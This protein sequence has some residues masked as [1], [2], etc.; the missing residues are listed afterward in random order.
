MREFDRPLICS[1]MRKSEMREGSQSLLVQF[2]LR[3]CRA[4]GLK[5]NG[6]PYSSNRCI[7]LPD[8]LRKSPNTLTGAFNWRTVGSEQKVGM[9][10]HFPLDHPMKMEPQLK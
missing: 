7:K 4:L 1:G 6:D 2:P 3:I 9:Q 5:L 10:N 8:Y